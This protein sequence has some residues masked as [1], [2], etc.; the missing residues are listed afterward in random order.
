LLR[1]AC[2][3]AEVD[4]IN[5]LAIGK[6]VDQVRRRPAYAAYFWWRSAIVSVGTSTGGAVSAG[7]QAYARRT[8]HPNSHAASA[9]SVLGDEAVA[10]LRVAQFTRL[11]QRLQAAGRSARSP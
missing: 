6:P 11:A 4:V 2:R 5:R 3:E 8:P 7:A 1:H 10:K 9:G